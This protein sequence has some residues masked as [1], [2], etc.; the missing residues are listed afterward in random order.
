MPSYGVGG[1]S[2]LPFIL[3]TFN[4]ELVH[5]IGVVWD[6]GI[7]GQGYL[8]STLGQE[9]PFEFRAYTV[10]SIPPQINRLDTEEEPGEQTFHA[11]WARAQH[12]WFGGAGQEVFDGPNSSRYA[13]KASKGINI[14]TEGRIGLMMDTDSLYSFAAA[15]PV[16]DLLADD[17]YLF[18]GTDDDVGRLDA[19]ESG[20]LDW[21]TP[22]V[23]KNVRCLST[24]GQYIYACVQTDGIFREAISTWV[25]FTKINNLV[26]NIM[27][28]VKGRL[29]CAKNERLHQITDYTSLTDGASPFYTHATA[30]WQWTSITET[31]VAIYCA[32][33]SGKRSAIYAISYDASDLSAGLVLGMPRL[34]WESPRGEIIH[35]INGYMGK[36]LMIGTSDGVRRGIVADETGNLEVSA[37]IVE[38]EYPVKCF[39]F[40]KD[41]CWFGWSYF[42]N[43]SSG[44]GRIHLGDVTYASDLMYDIQ[45]HITSIAL[46]QGRRVFS[47]TQGVDTLHRI[48]K[49]HATDLVSSGYLTTGEI[50]FGTFE[51]KSLRYFD[52]LLRGSGGTMSLG[53]STEYGS[54][55]NYISGQILGRFYQY[56]DLS[57]SRF[58]LKITLTRDSG[59]N[60]KGPYL[61]EW[62]L[63]ADP[64]AMG[65]FRYYVPVMLY[66]KMRTLNGSAVGHMGYAYERL[67]ELMTL[68]RDGTIFTLQTPAYMLP[69]GEV[70]IEVKLEGIQFKSFTP[71]QGIS[72]VGG[73]CLLIMAEQI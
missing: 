26:P 21:L 6:L 47:T 15:N 73:V 43:T 50:R 30:G 27:A 12:T 8:L 64:V 5:G 3:E 35:A 58:N 18:W 37:L 67:S 32:G 51:N 10:E 66:D 48:I 9:Y 63:R 69:R 36:T 7:N 70:E 13:F 53:I 14:W 41:Y 46:F 39:A 25:A 68:F 20:T 29:L 38:T 11:W 40:N 33:Y 72:G 34:V 19:L 17:D 42:D 71:P 62:R 24:D 65:R 31:G 59:D 4:P 2:V 54:F 49:E 55:V 23:G 16:I 22:S 45:A 28:F 57:G 61:L 44:I 1:E 52:G 60:T 56:L